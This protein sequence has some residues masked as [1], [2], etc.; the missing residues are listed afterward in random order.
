MQR[1]IAILLVFLLSIHLAAEDSSLI[2]ITEGEF[3]MG[4]P[5]GKGRADERPRHKV[6]LDTY[7]LD[8]YEVT[9]RQFADFL[10]TLLTVENGKIQAGSSRRGVI[11]ELEPGYEIKKLVKIP[12]YWLTLS[13][14]GFQL[15][16]ALSG[17]EAVFDVTWYGADSY[18]KAQ[19]KRLPTEAEWEKACQAGNNSA[20]SFGDSSKTLGDYAWYGKNSSGRAAAGRGVGEKKPNTWGLYDMHGDVSE[21][22]ADWYTEDFYKNSA[23]KNP[24]NEFISGKKVVRGGSRLDKPFDLRCAARGGSE[25]SLTTVNIGFRCAKS[26]Q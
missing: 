15:N 1:V 12:S 16:S 18:C 11:G 25:S 21:W 3:I 24:I 5:A 6:M 26:A 17:S 10:G 2:L 23:L 14:D 8:K 7:Y 19:G 22:T 20:Y 4:S 13:E 9:W